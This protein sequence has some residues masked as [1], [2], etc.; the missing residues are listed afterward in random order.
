MPKYSS[1]T[2]CRRI[3]LSL[4]DDA[5]G[6]IPPQVHL[7]Q[8]PADSSWQGPLQGPHIASLLSSVAATLRSDVHSHGQGGVKKAMVLIP[9]DKRMSRIGTKSRGCSACRS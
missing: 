4:R 5:G 6:S 9:S 7:R 8:C 2:I 1:V 3:L